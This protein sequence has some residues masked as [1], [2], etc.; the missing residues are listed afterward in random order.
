MGHPAE[1]ENYHTLSLREKGR[2]PGTVN[3]VKFPTQAK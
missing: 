2:H 3:K 1:G